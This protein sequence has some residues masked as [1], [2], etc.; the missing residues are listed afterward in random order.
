MGDPVPVGRGRLLLGDLDLV[1]FKLN[2]ITLASDT[3]RQADVWFKS[4]VLH[5][6]VPYVWN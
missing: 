1:C 4:A 5:A 6:V 3:S 2:C